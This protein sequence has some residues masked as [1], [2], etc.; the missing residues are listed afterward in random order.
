M[1]MKANGG[2]YK[3]GRIF[4]GLE[5]SA[6]NVNNIISTGVITKLSVKYSSL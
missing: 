6:L 1:T 3:T 2:E 4:P 5:Y